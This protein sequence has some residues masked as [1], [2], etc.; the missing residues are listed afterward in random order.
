MTGGTHCTPA[1]CPSMTLHTSLD[2]Y[3]CT[4]LLGTVRCTALLWGQDKTLFSTRHIGYLYKV[5][6]LECIL[7]TDLALDSHQVGMSL[8]THC[9]WRIARIRFCTFCT[10]Q[11]SHTEHSCSGMA[12][13][14]AGRPDSSHRYITRTLSSAGISDTLC[15][16]LSILQ[17]S[18]ETVLLDRRSEDHL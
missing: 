12:G 11:Q 5:C 18:Q 7:H 1:S 8:H 15:D 4:C 16:S 14:S 6:N 9:L 3:P 17:G 10:E 2:G 13:I